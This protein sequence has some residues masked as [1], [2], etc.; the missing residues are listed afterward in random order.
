MEHLLEFRR[1]LTASLGVLW[2]WTVDFRYAASSAMR[3]ALNRPAE[4]D[5]QVIKFLRTRPGDIFCDIGC[6]RGQSIESFLMF[7]KSCQV[8]AFEP[9]PI[10]FAKANLRYRDNPRVKIYNV[11]LSAEHSRKTLFLPK[12]RKTY[13]DE[14]ASFDREAAGK[15]FSERR[16][17]GFD[18]RLISLAEFQC[19]LRT[20]DEYALSP[21]FVKI[22][23]QGYEELVLHG[24]WS[25]IKRC[26][27]IL[28]IE[29]DERSSAEMVMELVGKAGYL[30]Y[31]FD[32]EILRR[33]E[34]G[35]PNTFYMV[36][37]FERG[38]EQMTA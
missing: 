13:F 21:V 38:L 30:P 36:E 8:I 28:L 27:P 32:G 15:W 29:N 16:L 37:D 7:N 33:N 4:K 11:G 1:R 5:F 24:A 26:K 34:I 6:N 20:L 2:P 19:D 22:D 9:N 17:I 25:T 10:T 18:C 31:R 23:V 3:R 35:S 14:L 12:Y